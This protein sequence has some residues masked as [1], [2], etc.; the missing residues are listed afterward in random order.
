MPTP[1]DPTPYLLAL[2]C[3]PRL[4]PATLT[5]F[6]ARFGT[7]Q[8]VWEAST[9][10]LRSVSPSVTEA[11]AEAR[12]RI[13]PEA[14]VEQASRA[15]CAVT[16]IGAPDYPPV[17]AEVVT[18]P[19]ALYVRGDL[20]ALS[21]APTV[22]VVGTRRASAYGLRVTE[23]M[24]EGLARAGVT[25][26]SGMARGIDDAAHRRTLSVG[27]RTVAV[28]GCG[29]DVCYPPES[30]A[31]KA[32]IESNGAVVSPFPPGTAPQAPNFPA[33]NR[34]VSGLS[35]AVVVVE[36]AL[37]SGAMITAGFAIEQER[38][39]FAVAGSVLT[40]A[41]AGC[42]RLLA[43]GTATLV[44]G[45]DDVLDELGLRSVAAPAPTAP[46][47]D[48]AEAVLAAVRGGD[49]F[50][51]GGWRDLEEIVHLSGMPSHAVVRILMR[52]EL[53]GHVHRAAGNRYRAVG[54]GAAVG[55]TAPHSQ[56]VS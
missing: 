21:D 56:E 13:R 15:G 23:M 36:A 45:A 2:A 4:G 38:P 16:T 28:L 12:R 42:N 7:P 53:A 44:R 43:E 11:I 14:L 6:L 19:I 46:L 1:T 31:L 26:V 34:I 5:R 47:D 17:L 52:M 9:E 3:V 39:L 33:R 51:H 48:E 35:R 8:A 55:A 54:A 40:E 10:A 22:A 37:R 27:G 49:G 18:A 41:A 32:A 20:T 24:A 30:R 50:S 29:A 25:V